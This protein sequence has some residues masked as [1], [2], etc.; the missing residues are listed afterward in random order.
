[1]RHMLKVVVMVIA[2]PVAGFAEQARTLDPVVVTATKLETPAERLGAAVTVITDEDLGARHYESVAD[3]LRRVP[4]LEVQQSGGPGKL[5]SIR[6]RGAG[7][8]QVQVLIDGVRVKSP[9]TGEF[10]FADLS[11]DLIDR[12]EIVRGPQSTLYG[13]DAIGGVVHIITKRGRGPLTARL[14]VEGGNYATHRERLSLRGSR[15]PFD[16]AL[17]GSFFETGS[18]LPNDDFEQR[19]ANGRVGLALPRDGHLSLSARYTKSQ[20]D[21]PIDFVVPTRPFHVL[22]PNSQQSSELLTLSLEWQQKPVKWWEVRARFGEVWNWFEFRDP[23]EIPPSRL[24]TER[25][26]VELVNHFHPAKWATLS[27]GVE[28]RTERG[29]IPGTLTEE[30]GVLSGFVQQ[31]VRILDRLFLSGGFRV[32]DNDAFG[33]ETTARAGLVYLVKRWGTRVRGTW[34]QGFRA[35]TINDLFFPGFGNPDLEPEKSE[36]WDAGID[37]RLWGDRIRLGATYFHNDFRQLIQ[38]ATLDG[39]VFRP[40]NVAKAR[41]WGLEFTGEADVLDNLLLT[42]NYTY[43]DTENLETGKP[44]RR[45][46]PHRWNFGL[47][48]DPIKALSLFAEAHVASSQFEAEGFPRNPGY[49]RIDVGGT[50]RLIERRGAFPALALTARINNVTDERYME[51]FG[52]PARGINALAG[53]EARY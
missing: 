38:I 27:A 3:A 14:G 33:T 25:R 47:S 31:E 26:E 30:I 2:V 40:E 51:V 50:W 44:L 17:S 22:D 45:F 16:Y 37:Q 39:I 32:E 13:A 6:I 41:T 19:A 11:P 15:G 53:I 7:S 8:T 34:G 12:I 35:P 24:H 52:F 10:D 9:T 43:T 1:M 23:D 28:H 21:L 18:Q 29:V 48:W 5:T 49:H 46:A 36:S 42:V 4:G 20:T